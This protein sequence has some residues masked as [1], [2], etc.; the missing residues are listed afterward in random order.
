M[1]RKARLLTTA[2]LALTLLA[3]PV[4]EALAHTFG[5]M[6]RLPVPVWMY[7]YGSAAALLLSFLVVGYFVNANSLER[8]LQQRSLEGSAF[9]RLWQTQPVL[10]TLRFLSVFAL[11]LSIATGLWG[12][13][14]PYN[15]INMTLFWVIFV[16][17]YAY[18]VAL[19]GNSYARLNP[20]LVLCDYLEKLRPELFS[21]R[22]AYPV[23][24]A[25]WPAFIFYVAFISV[26]LFAQ[27]KPVSLAWYLLGYSVMNLLA[28]YVFG[29]KDWFQYGELFAV[30]LRIF[31]LA[32]PLSRS[33]GGGLIL[34]QPFMGLSKRHVAHV[35]LLLFILFMLSSTAVDGIKSTVPYVRI[36][37]VHVAEW[38]KPWVGDDIVYSFPILK[39][40]YLYWQI[41]VLAL[42]PALYFAVYLIFVWLSKRVAATEL[43][44][45][46]LALRY[47][48]S[49]V[50]IA[51]VYHVTHYYPLLFSQGTQLLKFVSDPF[52]WGWNLFG[53]A[54][55][56]YSY[57]VQA[58]TIW[59]TQ[60]WLIV[61][62]HIV[63]VY[64][65]H[66]EALKIYP[67]PRKAALSQLPML[68]LMVV[69][70]AAGLWML[71]LPISPT[72]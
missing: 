2:T 24:L 15:N 38:L 48:Y 46:Q 45:M 65:A 55:G 33:E 53:T 32:S 12:A 8:N 58:G 4:A 13:N 37:W 60:V 39:S 49:L 42:S 31:G 19:F 62:G 27:T 3:L 72:R 18:W 17:G 54:D 14:H 26:E 6:Y 22:V 63:S 1:H 10:S 47:G 44:V 70:T 35:S 69:F 16:L 21:G 66:M 50:P 29:R 20:W 30:F 61:F 40:I 34:G 25:Y 56:D 51:L 23:G 7:L 64:L 52:G 28:A 41:G 11:L 68:L 67:T 9:F 57:I 36:Y 5:Q 43:G 71:S 59:H